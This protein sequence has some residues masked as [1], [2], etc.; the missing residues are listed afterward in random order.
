MYLCSNPFADVVYVAPPGHGKSVCF[1][2]PEVLAKG[3]TIVVEPLKATI[4][5]QVS[6]LKEQVV[7]IEQ[8][9]SLEDAETQAKSTKKVVPHAAEQLLMIVD[10]LG[11]SGRPKDV[12]DL[13]FLTPELFINHCVFNLIVQLAEHNALERVVCD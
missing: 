9:Y 1:V 6:K 3:I 5:T 13:L 7:V 8:L 10:I 11:S 2:I 12:P 4:S